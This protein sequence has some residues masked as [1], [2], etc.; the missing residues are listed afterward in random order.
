MD[1]MGEIGVEWGN[2]VFRRPTRSRLALN[3]NT[4]QEI[5]G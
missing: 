1:E 3:K 4:T 2:L 5:K